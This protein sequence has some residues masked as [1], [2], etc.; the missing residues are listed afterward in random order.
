[1]ATVDWASDFYEGKV[2]AALDTMGRQKALNGA[3]MSSKEISDFLN[4]SL[5]AGLGAAQARQNSIREFETAKENRQTQKEIAQIHEAGATARNDAQMAFNY[6]QLR[7]TT[8]STTDNLLRLGGQVA[9]SA[10]TLGANKLFPSESDK[11]MRVY[12]EEALRRMGKNPDGTDMSPS[13]RAGVT[14]NDDWG[15]VTKE[16]ADIWNTQYGSDTV[17]PYQGAFSSDD[18]DRYYN[19]PSALTGIEGGSFGSD[20]GDALGRGLGLDTNTQAMSDTIRQVYDN[21]NFTH[22][23]AII[24]AG[25]SDL[26]TYYRPESVDFAMNTFSSNLGV[27]ASEAIPLIEIAYS[28]GYI[29]NSVGTFMDWNFG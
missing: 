11:T 23:Q 8:P 24:D 22:A 25:G 10:L 9:G 26:Y 13:Q 16:Q 19:T 3:E 5:S 6:K 28:P 12:R 27:S 29:D 20:M 14:V 15:D 2:K 18:L 17:Q 1:M 7:E 21:P 4:P